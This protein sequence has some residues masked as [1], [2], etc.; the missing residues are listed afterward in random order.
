M[1]PTPQD[2]LRAAYFQYTDAGLRL[3]PVPRSLVDRFE[4]FGPWHYG[5]RDCL[6]ADRASLVA[7]A[8][9]H[10]TDDY[11]S[12]AHVGHGANSWAVALRF[13]HGPLAVF[14]RHPWGGAHRDPD[15]DSVAVHSSF[16]RLEALVARAASDGRVSTSKRLL[17][18]QDA[19]QGGGWKP[20]GGSWQASADPIGAALAWLDG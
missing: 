2:A 7:E 20:P 18:V 17:V 3:P 1:A 9:H 13:V 8:D 6:A 14:V 19:Q 5:T 4:N 10:D 16:H 12:F 15:V 11:L